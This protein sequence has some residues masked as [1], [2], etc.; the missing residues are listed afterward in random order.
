MKSLEDMGPWG[1]FIA[2]ILCFG[3][4]LILYLVVTVAWLG[5]Q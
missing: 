3:V 1:M 4:C 5:L 2:G